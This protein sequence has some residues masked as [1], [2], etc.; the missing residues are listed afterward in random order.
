MGLREPRAEAS[1]AVRDDPGILALRLIVLGKPG[2][3]KGTQARRLVEDRGIPAISTGDLIRA[4]I[5]EDSPLGREFKSFTDKGELVPDSL[6]VS[7][8]G[9]RLRKADCALG[10]LL[11]GFPRTIPQAEALEDW[12]KRHE[13]VLDIVLNID[14]PDD[15]L[16]ER[17]AGRR[18]CTLCGATFHITFAPPKVDNFC[19]S[20]GGEGLVQRSDDRE[21]VVAERLKQYAAKTAPL[22]DFYDKRNLLR[23]VEGVGSL[24]EVA[25]RISAALDGT[26]I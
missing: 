8:V 11:D 1:V 3:G 15:V 22:V 17:A 23:T 12:M 14:V 21:N 13:L 9:E 16:V 25:G 20:C 4:A 7:L 24:D 26:G 10:F 5:A 19:D 18:S 6:I 2:S